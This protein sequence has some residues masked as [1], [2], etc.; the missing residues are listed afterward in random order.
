MFLFPNAN[1]ARAR[2]QLTTRTR[3]PPMP[4]RVPP[5]HRT[6]VRRQASPGGG[7]WGTSNTTA[8]AE[9][10]SEPIGVC[11]NRILHRLAAHYQSSA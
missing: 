5:L 6:T 11:A 2:P 9:T 1:V 3:S 10:G 8:A 7:A 4:R